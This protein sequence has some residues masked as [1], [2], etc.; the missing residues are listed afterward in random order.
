MLETVRED[1][2]HKVAWRGL[3]PSLA[4]SVRVLGSE[5]SLGQ[6]LY[7]AMRFCQT[8]G[9]RLSAFL[10]YRLNAQVGHVIIGRDADIGP[11]FTILHS[12][13]IVINT[14]V[15]AGK[16]LVLQHQVTLGER[17]GRSPVLGDNVFVGAGA[18][19]LGPVRV[20]NDVRIGANAVVTGDLPDGATAVGVPARVVR[21]YGDPV[22]PRGRPI[23]PTPDDAA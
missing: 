22:N 20:G 5:G 15:K 10:L 2:R 17:R 9:L 19:V 4:S 6:L 23:T 18:K 21:I 3:A 7:R 16:N 8:R 14:S 13:G 11:G 12:S 1:L